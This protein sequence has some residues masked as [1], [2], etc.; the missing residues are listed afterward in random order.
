[1]SDPTPHARPTEADRQ[2]PPGMPRWV[3]VAGIVVLALISL[4]LVLRLAGL[5]G[6]HGPGRHLSPAVAPLADVQEAVPEGARA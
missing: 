4:F 6:D 1:M 5:G 3:T 2:A